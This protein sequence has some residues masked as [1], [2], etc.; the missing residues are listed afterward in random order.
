[1]SDGA[2][3]EIDDTITVH[4]TKSSIYYIG[5]KTGRSIGFELARLIFSEENPVIFSYGYVSKHKHEDMLAEITQNAESSDNWFHDEIKNLRTM[6][7]AIN[8][9]LQ[10]QLAEQIKYTNKLEDEIT[11]LKRELQRGKEIQAKA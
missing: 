4:T 3:I 7:I 11:A 1:M 6:S 8:K 5:T 10:G 2:K 9:D